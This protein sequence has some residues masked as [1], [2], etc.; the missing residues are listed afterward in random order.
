MLKR[1][2]L[3]T[4]AVL[5]MFGIGRALLAPGTAR[6]QNVECAATAMSNTEARIAT[7]VGKSTAS[8]KAVEQELATPDQLPQELTEFGRTTARL[9]QLSQDLANDIGAYETAHAAKMAE[10]DQELQA[11]KDQGTRRPIET[12]GHIRGQPSEPR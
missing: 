10:F 9:R 5:T 12:E 1:V 11:I 4:L 2:L 8:A 3:G 7:Q 6:A